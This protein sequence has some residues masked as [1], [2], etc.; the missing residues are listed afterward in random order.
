MLDEIVNMMRGFY[1]RI[2]HLQANHNA[3]KGEGYQA[4]VLRTGGAYQNFYEDNPFIPTHYLQEMI[5]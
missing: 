5:R 4:A 2:V 1:E 3:E